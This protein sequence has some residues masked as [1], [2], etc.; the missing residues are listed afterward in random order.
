VN[1]TEVAPV[2]HAEPAGP[3]RMR[4]FER[5]LSLWVALCMAA[6]VLLGSAAPGLIEG[7]RSRPSAAI[8][9][10]IFRHRPRSVRVL[11]HR[12]TALLE[13]DLKTAAVAFRPTGRPS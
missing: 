11:L 7:L 13:G 10:R 9:N 8:R 6:G 1:A 5:Y 3:K 4:A 12:C 2:A